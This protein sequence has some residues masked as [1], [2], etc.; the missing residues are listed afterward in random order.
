ML[1]NSLYARQIGGLLLR[2]WQN[3]THIGIIRQG[4]ISRFDRHHAEYIYKQII[5]AKKAYKQPYGCWEES[6]NGI[7]LAWQKQ[8]WCQLD[9]VSVWKL[10]YFQ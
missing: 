3:W 6:A 9:Y 5:K 7:G 10:P 8:I 4:D 1:L 2:T